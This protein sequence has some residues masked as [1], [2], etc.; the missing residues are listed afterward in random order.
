MSAVDIALGSASPWGVMRA[1][2]SG[3]GRRVEPELAEAA[4]GERPHRPRALKGRWIEHRVERGQAQHPV[5]VS[6]RPLAADRSADVVDDQM[7][8][9]DLEGLERL[10]EPRGE[11]R[12]RVVEALGAV[13][14]PEAGEV[15]RDRVQALVG[16][17]ADHLAV[18]ER[19]RRNPVHEHDGRARSLLAD[20]A[21]HAARLEA[22]PRGAVDV[23]HLGD[24][25]V[26][27]A[28]H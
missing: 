20:E 12:P 2:N 1:A 5:R 10:A 4:D 11:P 16:E 13:R 27:G 8:A 18:R 17:R 15:E 28:D 23:D 21:P 25:C 3:R 26:H 19:A 24:L 9:T 7:A 14:E 22:A 6:D